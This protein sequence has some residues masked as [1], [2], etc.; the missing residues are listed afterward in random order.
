MKSLNTMHTGFS[1]VDLLIAL[2]IASIF[3]TCSILSYKHIQA[4]ILLNG[5]EQELYHA[6]QQYHLYQMLNPYHLDDLTAD[7]LFSSNRYYHFYIEQKN[8]TTLFSAQK[9][10]PD[11]HDICTK[12]TLDT[13]ETTQGYNADGQRN[14]HC[15]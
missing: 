5:A 13:H 8:L 6:M 9:I 12:I 2:T 7:I 1:L 11:Y 14:T 15:W 4:R 10:S 3:S